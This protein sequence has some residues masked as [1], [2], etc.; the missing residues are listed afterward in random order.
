MLEF[1]LLMIAGFI[2]GYQLGLTQRKTNYDR[3]GKNK[4]TR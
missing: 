1:T 4:N 3:T 2:L